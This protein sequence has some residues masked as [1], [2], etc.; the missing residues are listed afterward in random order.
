MIQRI[1]NL[2]YKE[3]LQFSRD[4]LMVG[5]MIIGP[6]LQLSLM[7]FATGKSV[8]NLS[9]AVLDMD[10]SATS[11]AIIHSMDATKALT[12]GDYAENI[13]DLTNLIQNGS[14]DVGVI[15]PP[16][17]ERD[18]NSSYRT[19]QIQ[20]IA[21]ATNNNAN[22]AALSAAQGAISSYLSGRKAGINAQWVDLR[23]DVRFNPT[24]DTRQYTIPAMTGMIIFE[25]TLLLASSA[26]SRE[27]EMG[28]LEQLIIMPFQRI[29]IIIGKAVPPVLLTLFTFPFMLFIAVD[30]F[31]V[32]MRGSAL[33]L[34]GLTALFM[35]AEVSWGLT[36][37]TLART[38]QQ[39]ILFVFVQAIVDVT[40][41]GFLVPIESMPAG[42]SLISNL[43]PLRHYLIIIRGIM[44]K[45]ASIDALWPQIIALA[46]L[47][48]A[49]SIFARF[50]LGK[51]FD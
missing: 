20:V 31:G 15:I 21:G 40:F 23:S 45:G 41:S 12:L 2:I 7:A 44:L 6:I 19:P 17:F 50:N 4:R 16:G 10:H 28:T 3:L 25:L 30:L 49:M 8:E 14:T 35:C 32:P 11:R 38:Q 22:F 34:I 27:R 42:I 18:L 47:T 5:F 29:E 36:L 24:F 43:V 33:L 9:L 48:I 46:L 26:L 39:S 1:L 51:H 13:D 37:S